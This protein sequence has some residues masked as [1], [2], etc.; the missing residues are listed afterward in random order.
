LA[1]VDIFPSSGAR[2]KLFLGHSESAKE[3]L[4]DFLI[5][6]LSD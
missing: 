5:G 3:E 2:M 4:G 6:V 1:L